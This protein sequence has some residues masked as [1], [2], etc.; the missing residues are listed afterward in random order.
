MLIIWKFLKSIAG[1]VFEAPAVDE[2][3]GSFVRVVLVSFVKQSAAA[4]L[5]W[6]CF[7]VCVVWTASQR[8]QQGGSQ[9]TYSS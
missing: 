4:R 5:A 6:S 9:T 3:I 1:R 7:V 2:P 8:E